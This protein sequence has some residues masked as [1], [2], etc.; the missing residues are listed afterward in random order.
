MIQMVAATSDQVDDEERDIDPRF[1][2][3]GRE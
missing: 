1:I 2:D 3:L